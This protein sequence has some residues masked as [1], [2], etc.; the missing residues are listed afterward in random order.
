[1]FDP[2]QSSSY[3]GTGASGSLVS[4]RISYVY[5]KFGIFRVLANLIVGLNGPSFTVDTACSSSL[6]SVDSAIKAMVKRVYV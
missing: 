5:G 3:S 1:M 6:V 2:M 4:N